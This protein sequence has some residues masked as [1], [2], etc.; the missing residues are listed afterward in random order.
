M[1]KDPWDRR[2]TS[3]ENGE[4]QNK[5]D[6]RLSQ[7]A[8]SPRLEV[9]GACILWN[10]SIRDFQRR[11]A[12]YITKA[13]EQLLILL[14]DMEAYRRFKQNNLFLS[15]KRNLTMVSSLSYP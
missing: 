9:D 5:V 10:T 7:R 4:E 15:L 2:F 3:I 13:L 11:R 6:V 8:W 1:A 12:S 14:K